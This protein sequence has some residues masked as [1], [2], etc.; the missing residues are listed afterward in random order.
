VSSRTRPSTGTKLADVVSLLMMEQVRVGANQTAFPR[1]VRAHHVPTSEPPNPHA[2]THRGAASRARTRTNTHVRAAPNNTLGA[3]KTSRARLAG[4][5]SSRR[6]RARSRWRAAA[7]ARCRRSTGDL[8]QGRRRR[9]AR[10]GWRRGQDGE[11][12]AGRAGPHPPLRRGGRH[13][14]QR[15]RHGHHQPDAAVLHAVPPVQGAVR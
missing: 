10:G 5:K 6:R 12:R 1:H 7:K 14:R 3:V 4:L 15:H 8:R 2:R 11:P 13:R 9:G